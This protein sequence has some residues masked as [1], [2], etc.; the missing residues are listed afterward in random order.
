LRRGDLPCRQ[1]LI[2]WG[3]TSVSLD[4]RVDQ[5]SQQ[6]S[7][8]AHRAPR[9]SGAGT[10]RRRVF[11][12]ALIVIGVIVAGSTWRFSTQDRPSAALPDATQP[13]PVQPTINNPASGPPAPGP[14]F[15]T[16]GPAPTTWTVPRTTSPRTTPP[17]TTPS[18]PDPPA[19]DVGRIGGG[20]RPRSPAEPPPR[21]PAS[22]AA[23]AALTPVIGT[24]RVVDTFPDGFIGEVAVA[25]TSGKAASWQVTL[26][27]P[28]TVTDLRTSWVDGSPPPTVRRT[29]QTVIFTS[30]QPVSPGAGA[31]TRARRPRR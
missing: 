2:F 11:L 22:P 19:P 30:A 26:Q 10:P 12:S 4:V 20:R 9:A 27:L 1:L 21:P 15:P 5:Q 18:R 17:R 14:S 31:R 25:N 16:S 23:E 28:D 7:R 29:G 24:Y 13:I 6:H 8:G 3:A